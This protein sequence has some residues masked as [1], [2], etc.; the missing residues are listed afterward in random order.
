MS[1]STKKT[2]LAAKERDA[3]A[4]RGTAET[5]PPKT[6][7]GEKETVTAAEESTITT[8]G[9]MI[10]MESPAQPT[11]SLVTPKKEDVKPVVEP[12]QKLRA[13]LSNVIKQS[14]DRKNNALYS[15]LQKFRPQIQTGPM[16]HGLRDA[17]FNPMGGAKK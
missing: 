4:K 9:T 16:R 5:L 13:S 12:M 11:E 14:V 7:A 17:R 3:R 2:R 6:K 1:Q 8:A 15:A 10:E